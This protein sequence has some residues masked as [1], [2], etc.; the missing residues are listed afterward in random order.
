T[1]DARRGFHGPIQQID[2]S[3]D[4]GKALAAIPALSDLPE[5]RLAVVLAVSDSTVAT[6]Q[7]DL[8]GSGAAL[9]DALH[10]RGD[11]V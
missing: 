5:C 10:H 7:I 11:L 2:A 3:G 1:Y 4:W 6:A 9:D 8:A